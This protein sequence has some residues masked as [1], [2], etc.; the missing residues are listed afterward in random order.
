MTS[1][2]LSL[3]ISSR[4]IRNYLDDEYETLQKILKDYDWRIRPPGTG[5]NGKFLTDF[6]RLGPTRSDR[7]ESD[8]A[9]ARFKSDR[10]R[11]TRI[12]SEQIWSDQI[13][14]GLLVYNAGKNCL[15]GIL[16]RHWFQ[17]RYILS[18]NIKGGRVRIR[19]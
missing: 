3:M 18:I 7:L 9:K 15:K 19:D 8:W 12:G 11:S 16:G 10:L 4:G 5:S 17:I 14:T 2:F 13:G 1:F 6:D